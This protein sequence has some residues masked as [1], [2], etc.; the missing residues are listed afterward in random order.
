MVTSMVGVWA[1]HKEF[2]SWEWKMGWILNSH[3][4]LHSSLM[5][6]HLP[7]IWVPKVKSG[8][9]TFFSV[10]S[11]SKSFCLNEYVYLHACCN[12]RRGFLIFMLF[13]SCLSQDIFIHPTKQVV[14]TNHEPFL[15]HAFPRLFQASPKLNS[16][17]LYTGI[18]PCI[19]MLGYDRESLLLQTLALDFVMSCVN[20]LVTPG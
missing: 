8:W 20:S 16:V 6:A 2:G 15:F 19:C 3:S 11:F 5:S 13:S 10:F 7:F 4:T 9:F 18:L 17:P 1:W 12:V 14:G